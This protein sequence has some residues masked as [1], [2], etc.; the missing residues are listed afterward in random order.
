MFGVAVG[1]DGALLAAGAAD[2]FALQLHRQGNVLDV[3][4]TE[5]KTKTKQIKKKIQLRKTHERF[6]P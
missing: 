4:C 5:K 6:H 1:A 3:V 2:G